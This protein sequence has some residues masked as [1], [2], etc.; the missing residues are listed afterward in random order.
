MDWSVL[1][2]NSGLLDSWNSGNAKCCRHELF[3][4]QENLSCEGVKLPTMSPSLSDFVGIRGR[5]MI[6]GHG[7]F[8]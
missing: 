5:E 8:P 7:K 1:S 4:A 2:W 3:M 6:F